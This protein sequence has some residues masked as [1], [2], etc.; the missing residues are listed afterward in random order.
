MINVKIM[1]MKDFVKE[2]VVLFM[3]I[4]SYFNLETTDGVLHFKNVK[5]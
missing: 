3:N 1:F 2:K 5:F 4:L